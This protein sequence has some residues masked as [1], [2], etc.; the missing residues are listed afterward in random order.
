MKIVW[1]FWGGI[2]EK[3]RYFGRDL[4]ICK[5]VGLE[6]VMFEFLRWSNIKGSQ[7]LR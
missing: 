5:T 4:L 1:V 7:K 6:I 3:I 2:L